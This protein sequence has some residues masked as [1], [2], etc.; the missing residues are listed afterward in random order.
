[1]LYHGGF[2]ITFFEIL[3]FDLDGKALTLQHM[4]EIVIEEIVLYAQTLRW[5][6][7]I[8]KWI[9]KKCTKCSDHKLRYTALVVGKRSMVLQWACFPN[10]SL[11]NFAYQNFLTTTPLSFKDTMLNYL[12]R[13]VFRTLYTTNGT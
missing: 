1:M 12:S 5:H 2:K 9:I 7:V 10:L 8:Y 11:F 13:I 4:E 6:L 3:V